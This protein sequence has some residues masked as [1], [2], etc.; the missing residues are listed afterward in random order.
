MPRNTASLYAT[1][2]FAVALVRKISSAARGKE[3]EETIGQK[4][5]QEVVSQFPGGSSL[6][7]PMARHIMGLRASVGRPD[8]VQQSIIGLFDGLASVHDSFFGEAEF[9]NDGT[10]KSG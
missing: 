5:V 4:A 10:P 2:A 9:E 8:L 3:D 1:S 6:W 7:E